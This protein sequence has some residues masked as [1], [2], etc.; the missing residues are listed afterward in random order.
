MKGIKYSILVFCFLVF[1]NIS[2]AQYV[3]LEEPYFEEKW[4][5][6]FETKASDTFVVTIYDTVYISDLDDLMQNFG[7]TFDEYVQ[8]FVKFAKGKKS[9][10]TADFNHIYVNYFLPIIG[11][12]NSYPFARHYINRIYE[13]DFNGYT[14]QLNTF[15]IECPDDSLQEALSMDVMF[16]CRYAQNTDR[17]ICSRSDVKKNLVQLIQSLNDPMLLLSESKKQSCSHYSAVKSN[18][19][20]NIFTNTSSTHIQSRNTIKGV[21]FYFPDF[22]FHEKRAMA[23]FI[24]SVSLVFDS[25]KNTNI[26][27]LHY[28]FMF[29]KEKGMAN[30]TYLAGMV[31]HSDTIFLIEQNSEINTIMPP[32]F[33]ISR[34]MVDSIPLL[35]KFRNQIYL[36]RFFTDIFPKTSSELSRSDIELLIDSDY[37]NNTW[38]LYMYILFVLMLLILIFIALYKSIPLVSVFLNR[39]SDY[40]IIAIIIVVLE[41]LLLV[42]NMFENMSKDNVLEIGNGQQYIIFLLPLFCFI[43]IPLLKFM[44]RNKPKP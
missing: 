30:L 22:S 32:L 37:P 25:C 9:L 8:R 44:G 40:Y 36:A 24:K 35:A 2:E 28:Y 12:N 15:P 17:F 23:Q 3:Y 19:C 33:I 14:F 29:D 26:R 13:L 38:E 39:N 31:S 16:T 4:V 34:E 18:A 21:I 43:I 10:H 1:S 20:K 5:E 42:S 27:N 7:M 41:L 11:E 6:D